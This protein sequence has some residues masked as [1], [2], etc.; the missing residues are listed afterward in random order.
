MTTSVCSQCGAAT[1]RPGA[2][3]QTKLCPSCGG[4][5]YG[6]KHR[7][8]RAAKLEDAYFTACFRC[9]RVMLPGQELHLDHMDGAGPDD[10]VP[11]LFSHAKCNAAAGGRR[12]R[13]PLGHRDKPARPA[14]DDGW[15]PARDWLN[16]SHGS[17]RGA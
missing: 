15:R 6:R 14:A 7:E 12:N 4:G 13:L 10:Y 9:G 2:G 16:A 11:S 17:R 3:R 8:L 5:R 1:F